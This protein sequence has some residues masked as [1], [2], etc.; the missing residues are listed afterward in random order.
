MLRKTP[1]IDLKRAS[2]NRLPARVVRCLCFAMVLSI[3]LMM[4]TLIRLS[5]VDNRRLEVGDIK[6]HRPPAAPPSWESFPFLKRYYGGIRSLVTKEDNVPEYPRAADEPVLNYTANLDTRD[7]PSSKPFI[8]YPYATSEYRES[9]VEVQEC[10]VDAAETVRIPK[11][12]AYEGRVH[13]FPDPVA[14]SHELLGIR[15]DMCFERFGRLGPYGYGYTKKQ[16]GAGIGQYTEKEGSERVWQTDPQVDYSKVDWGYVQKRC[17]EANTAR[18]VPESLGADMGVFKE[19]FSAYD[20]EEDHGK[21]EDV[22]LA[23][24]KLLQRSALVIRTW[25]EYVYREED[26]LYLR[27]LISELAIGSGGEYDVHLLVHVKDSRVPIW[28]DAEVYKKHL[29]EHVPEEFWSITTLWSETQMLMLY[30][31]LYDTLA[32]GPD[33]PVHGVYRG[34]QMAMQHFAHNHPQYAFFWQWELDIR[35]TGHYYHLF[36]RAISWAKQQPRKGLWERSGRFYVPTVHGTWEDFKQMVRVH[37]EMGTD[38]A[39]T[40]FSKNGKNLHAQKPELDDPVWGPQ[41]PRDPND[42]FEIENDPEPPTTY[43]KDKYVWGVGEE[44]DLITFNPIF[45]PEGTTWGLAHD[46]TGYNTTEGLPPRRSAIVTAGRMSRRLLETMHRETAFKKHHAFSEMWPAMAAFQHG[47]K[48]VYIPHPM[49]IDR[50]WPT[51]YMAGVLNAGKNGA[52]GGARTSVFGDREHN[53]RG[54]TWYYNDG[55]SLNFW[56]R[57]LGFKVNNDGGEEEEKNGEGRICLPPL[58]LHPVKGVIVPLDKVT[59]EDDLTELSDPSA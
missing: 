36:D 49:Y 20:K 4:G 52:S 48:A 44:A 26:I 43:E 24:K 39:P 27:A 41:R 11:L 46:L 51:E 31:G 1:F 22:P 2:S 37:T 32:R 54:V 59:E 42:W 33:L 8:P 25:D 16:G 53:L 34:L 21:R 10:F 13:G 38:T 55:F 30:Q 56:L 47:Y 45:D 18:F 6:E 12:Q 57:W 29:R 19:S 28:A 58:L 50:E 23:N 35:Y 15:D 9:F 3:L 40:I 14:G 17:V 7:F 5:V